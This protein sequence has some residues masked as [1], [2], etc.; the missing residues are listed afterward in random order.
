M[1]ITG[2]DKYIIIFG[3]LWLKFLSN[4]L[5]NVDENFSENDLC[6]IIVENIVYH[7]MFKTK[8]SL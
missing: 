5:T 2:Y 1:C 4:T 8:K 7:H 3:A 6:F